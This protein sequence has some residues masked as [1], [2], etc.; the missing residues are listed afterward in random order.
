MLFAIH[1]DKPRPGY[2][3]HKHIHLVIDVGS[4]AQSGFETHQVCVQVAARFKSP[5]YPGTIPDG[6]YY[7]V[8]VYDLLRIKQDPAFHVLLRYYL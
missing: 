1:L 3:H 2:A 7:L 5:D 4:D 8:K 6:R